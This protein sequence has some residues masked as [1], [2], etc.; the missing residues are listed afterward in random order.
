LA[1]GTVRPEHG[2]EGV[3]EVDLE[4]VER[5]VV[6]DVVEGVLQ[7]PG[8]LRCEFGSMEERDWW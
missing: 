2:Q 4:V 7:L 1:A 5:D 6:R 3:V 8:D